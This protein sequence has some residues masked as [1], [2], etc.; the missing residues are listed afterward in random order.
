MRGKISGSLSTDWAAI[1]V[2]SLSV[3]LDCDLLM[4]VVGVGCEEREESKRERRSCRIAKR[5][6]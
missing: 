1:E 2:A 3:D 5:D 4:T 6:R